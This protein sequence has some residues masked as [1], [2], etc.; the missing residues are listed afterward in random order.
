VV[1][2]KVGIMNA[3]SLTEQV[4]LEGSWLALEQ[5]G[6]LIR[7]AVR[8]HDAGS[9][10][11]AAMLALFGREELGRSRILRKCSAEVHAGASLSVS[12]VQGRCDDHVQKQAASALSV[13]LM[14]SSYAD[15]SG[16]AKALRTYSR[17]TPNSS[18]WLE[19]KAIVDQAT[20]AK[21]ANQPSARHDARCGA[22]YVDLRENGTQWRR[23]LDVTPEEAYR[24]VNDAANDYAGECDRLVTI[25]QHPALAEHHPE[26]RA[27]EMH[28]ANARSARPVQPPFAGWP[29]L[30]A[31]N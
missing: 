31:S 17:A 6:T 27:V 20:A 2:L 28:E 4:L 22:L 1:G 3:N 13:V 14:T 19:A 12:D 18:E 24:H 23:P 10:A 11:T 25:P 29:K 26:M 16:L 30:G 21:S 8:M 5:A 7:D 9:H 15:Q